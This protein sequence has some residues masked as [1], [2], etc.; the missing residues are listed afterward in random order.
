MICPKCGHERSDK[1]DPL[2]PDYECPSCGIVYAKYQQKIK[3]RSEEIISN[4]QKSRKTIS[5]Q[6]VTS[7]DEE[8]SHFAARLFDNRIIIGSAVF[9]IAIGIFAGQSI[10]SNHRQKQAEI[11]K[12]TEEIRLARIKEAENNRIELEQRRKLQQTRAIEHQEQ[13]RIAQERKT[14]IE[15]QQK[16]R[17][18]AQREKECALSAECSF[19][20]LSDPPYSQCQHAVERLAK[21]DFEWT[22]KGWFTYKFNRFV[23]NDTTT[24]SSIFAGGDHLKLQNGFGAWQN[25]IYLCEVDA[26]SGSIINVAVK[27]GRF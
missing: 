3:Q 15:W 7:E 8:K 19:Q 13:T 17:L 21:Y 23:W 5:E 10:I 18:K 4:I 16:Q 14:Q 6:L 24:R 26:K 2:I 27:P 25:V 22:D 1:D 20:S 12:R 11:E 9:L